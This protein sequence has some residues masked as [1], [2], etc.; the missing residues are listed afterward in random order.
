MGSRA[1]GEDVMER[2][3]QS[4]RLP[5]AALV[6]LPRARQPPPAPDAPVREPPIRAAARRRARPSR[7]SLAVADAPSALVALLLCVNVLGR[8]QLS[9]L[10]L[11]G[12]PA[13]I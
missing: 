5:A 13:V 4:R 7:R 2:T 1:G 11:L 3:A 12:L 8:G 10:I 9:P 6:R